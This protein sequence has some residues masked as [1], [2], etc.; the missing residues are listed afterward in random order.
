M[1]GFL[2]NTTILM[3]EF[4]SW[5]PQTVS[6]YEV[7]ISTPYHG[8]LRK[9]TPQP[10]K[11][12]KSWPTRSIFIPS[13]SSYLIL[14]LNHPTRDRW[15]RRIDMKGA[16]SLRSFWISTENGNPSDAKPQKQP[17][18]R[19]K[20]FDGST[21][22]LRK[23]SMI[24][25]PEHLLW[26]HSPPKKIGNCRLCEAEKK[27]HNGHPGVFW[28]SW[29]STKSWKFERI[30][31]LFPEFYIVVFS[32]SFSTFSAS[33]EVVFTCF[34]FVGLQSSPVAWDALRWRRCRW[35]AWGMNGGDGPFWTIWTKK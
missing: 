12:P 8:E 35:G 2:A 19:L 30:A 23:V 1:W 9:N 17:P 18:T 21:V 26:S 16:A 3:F 4:S 20:R 34:F 25:M 14:N 7:K 13:I 29:W 24:S 22:R 10:W 27:G 28:V 6:L 32:T 11:H 15:D 33:W 5:E 31:D